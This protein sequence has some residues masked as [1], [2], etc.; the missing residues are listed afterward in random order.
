MGL[1]LSFVM[2][3]L[4]HRRTRSPICQADASWIPFADGSF[5][6]VFAAYVLDLMA[7]PV[8]PV[9]MRQFRRVLRPGGRLAVVAM[10]E[11]V[12]PA[13]RALVSVWKAVYAVSPKLCAGCR[14]LQLAEI[15]RQAGFTQVEA[16]VEVEWG[17]PSEVLVAVRS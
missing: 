2:A 14:P 10:T 16:Q 17:V 3:R 4:T 13:S 7:A 8:L 11:G 15:A 12:T 6:R 5:D 1:D 9:V